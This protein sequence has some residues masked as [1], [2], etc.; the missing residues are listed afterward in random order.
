MDEILIELRHGGK[1]SIQTDDI[2]NN[3]DAV[4]ETL[5][6]ALDALDTKPADVHPH[7][8]VFKTKK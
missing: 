6:T 7:E 2:Q 5:K 4:K 8:L 3:I 1:V